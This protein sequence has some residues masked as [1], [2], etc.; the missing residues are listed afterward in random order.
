MTHHGRSGRNWWF[1]ASALPLAAA[2]AVAFGIPGAAAQDATPVGEEAGRPAHIHSGS[3]GDDELG[4]VVAP[5][6]NLTEPEGD[7][8][9]N[10]RAV[11]AESSFTSVPLT[12]DALLAED[13]AV[14]IHLSA[15]EIGTY[16][17]CGEIGGPLA[18]D[19]S[20]QIGL[21]QQNDS[22]F[23]GIAFLAPG[24]DNASTDV[25]VFI[26]PVI[27]AEVG[28]GAAGD[29]EDE[30]AAAAGGEAVEVVLTEWAIDMPATLPAGPIT[31]RLVNDG[32]FPHTMEIEG[33]GFEEVADVV[34][35]GGETTFETELAPG[36]Y[37]VYCPVNDG[38]HRE[39]GMEIE[40]TVE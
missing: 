12:L 6:T 38:G 7:G 25:S 39:Q 23:T 18:G 31:F 8:G 24:A 9:G 1:G 37:T 34:E 10:E 26:A 20:L 21:K 22:G 5:L 29:D 17:A 30:E 40:V 2:L 32:E 11:V 4:D 15:E 13:F 35:A 3:C 36:T 19:G 27:D 28:G 14:N 16:I 33:E